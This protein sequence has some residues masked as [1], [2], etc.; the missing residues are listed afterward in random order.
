MQEYEYSAVPAP[1]RS[2]K[3]KGSKTP[4]DRYAVTLT[5]AINVMAAQGWEY[6][7]A[8]TLPS[9]ERSGLTGRTTLFHNLLIFRRPVSAG[10]RRADAPA[11]QPAAAP[12]PP[13]VTP[14]V[15]PPAGDP[16]ATLP[17]NATVAPDDRK[18][19]ET[20]SPIFSEKMRTPEKP[21]AE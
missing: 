14:P 5:E 17:T 12:R 4:A 11:A 3:T 21:G 1:A 8:E 7:R 18:A 6:L 10:K 19:D 2:E 20:G 13:S 15:T 9:E 16:E